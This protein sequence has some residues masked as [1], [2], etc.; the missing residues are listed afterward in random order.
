MAN[1]QR[2]FEAL[3]KITMDHDHWEQKHWVLLPEP[4]QFASAAFPNAEMVPVINCETSHCLF[5]QGCLD[6]GAIFVLAPGEQS[7]GN[8]IEPDQLPALLA[9][10]INYGHMHGAREYGAQWFELT[11]Q[12]SYEL[13][14]ACNSLFRLWALSFCL[15]DG[16]L[17]LPSSLPAI[18]GHRREEAIPD[19]R[20]EIREWIRLEHQQGGNYVVEDYLLRTAVA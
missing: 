7:A 16:T 11:P 20:R 8:L 4:A 9:G 19:L 12:E 2:L 6:A 14:S 1:A 3:M 5:G 17:S 18:G 15:T 10:E 13:S